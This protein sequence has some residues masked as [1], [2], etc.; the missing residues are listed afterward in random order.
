MG[1]VILD[2]F[3]LGWVVRLCWVGLVWVSLGCLF[4]LG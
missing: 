4:R 2:H 3:R 1:Y